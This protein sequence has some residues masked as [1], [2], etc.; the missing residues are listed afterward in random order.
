MPNKAPLPR[1]PAS[2]SPHD[3]LVKIHDIQVGLFFGWQSDESPEIPT[4]STYVNSTRDARDDMLERIQ[5]G[6]SDC[7]GEL[8]KGFNKMAELMSVLV[9]TRNTTHAEEAQQP[10]DF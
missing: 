8:E 1:E 9:N 7:I 10:K 2:I 5:H 6:D 4:Y 3:R